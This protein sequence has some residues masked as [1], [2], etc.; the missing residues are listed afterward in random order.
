MNK[1][2]GAK[3]LIKSADSI[4]EEFLT[5]INIE[6]FELY[7]DDELKRKINQYATLYAQICEYYLKA[8]ILPN[9]TNENYEE[10]SDE[11][12]S[13]LT[14]DKNGLRKYNHIFK[15]IINSN[16]FDEEVRR[17][18]EIYLLNYLPHIEFERNNVL[19]EICSEEAFENVTKYKN[20]RMIL[21]DSSHP[22]ICQLLDIICGET[23][24]I[25]NNSNAYSES[26]Y[27][28]ISSYVADLKFLSVFCDAIRE[29]LKLKFKNCFKVQGSKRHIFPD[30][31]T[32]IEI[33]YDNGNIQNMY[34]DMH[35]NLWLIN[36]DGKKIDVIGYIW[37]YDRIS[38]RE[39]SINKISFVENGKSKILI[40]DQSTG[41]Y[42]FLNNNIKSLENNDDLFN[43]HNF[44]K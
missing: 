6:N 10:N 44:R 9:L 25:S 2:E 28:M 41:E 5:K 19:K 18:M 22:D 15:R 3:E 4:Y 17:Y 16:D 43:S 39:A 30:I 37:N 24:L 33:V 26:R 31:E 40:R 38:D 13:F 23:G 12:M 42:I 34:L 7:D 27:A 36:D 20:L 14:F 32:N 21:N 29:S 11:E 1:I 8:L 35:E